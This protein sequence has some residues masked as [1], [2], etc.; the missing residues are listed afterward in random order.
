M[1]EIQKR[2]TALALSRIV[3]LMSS[4]QK[5][6]DLV[7]KICSSGAQ[8]LA[9]AYILL[10]FAKY[11]AHNDLALKAIKLAITRFSKEF[12]KDHPITQEARQ[13]ARHVKEE[14]DAFEKFHR[15]TE[16]AVRSG[17]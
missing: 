12:G 3:D 14:L 13:V 17:R 2:F 15:E 5:P 16:R 1:L 6:V 8:P 9:S 11:S 4:V 10:R 7:Y